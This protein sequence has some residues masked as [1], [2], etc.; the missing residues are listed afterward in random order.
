ME[1]H[2]KVECNDSN[3]SVKKKRDLQ[4]AGDTKDE[5]NYGAKIWYRNKAF[6][7]LRT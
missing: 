4:K 7:F 3:E 2:E 6:L 5:I 1:G